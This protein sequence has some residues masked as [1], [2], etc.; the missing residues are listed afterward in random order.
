MLRLSPHHWSIWLTSD[1]EDGDDDDGYR[2][3]WVCVR[4]AIA[5]GWILPR[6]LETMFD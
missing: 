4:A 3:W 5:Y 6:E 2:Q 1:D